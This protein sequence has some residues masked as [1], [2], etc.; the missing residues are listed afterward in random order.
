MAQSRGAQAWQAPVPA[1]VWEEVRQ[2]RGA[3]S[4]PGQ[5]DFWEAP[6]CWVAS[7]KPRGAADHPEFAL[8]VMRMTLST[9]NWRRREMVRWLVTCATEVGE[10]LAALGESVPHAVRMGLSTEILKPFLALGI[11]ALLGLPFLPGNWVHLRA[12]AGS[13]GVTAVAGFGT[14]TGPL[15]PG[16]ASGAR[17]ALQHGSAG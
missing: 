16:Q 10:C 14:G 7:L 11:G 1:V 5:R 9:L 8:Q 4:Q 13:A 15:F 3:G 17:C 2:H 12:P 6:L